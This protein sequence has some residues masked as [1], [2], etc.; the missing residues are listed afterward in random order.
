MLLEAGQSLRLMAG[1]LGSGLLQEVLRS[2][3]PTSV[4]V[5]QVGDGGS[6]PC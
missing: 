4:I 3:A 6:G 1:L 2:A 5:D